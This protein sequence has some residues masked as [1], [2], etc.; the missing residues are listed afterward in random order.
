MAPHLQR[1]RERESET[2]SITTVWYVRVSRNDD[3]AVN[4]DDGQPSASDEQIDNLEGIVSACRLTEVE[5][6]DVHTDAPRHAGVD[7]VF[8][9]DEGAEPCMAQRKAR[10]G[11]NVTRHP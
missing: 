3:Y 7:G 1:Y 9:V 5:R 6:V 8:C 4:Y 11:D 2:G 10:R